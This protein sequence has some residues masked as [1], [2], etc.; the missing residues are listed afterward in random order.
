MLPLQVFDAD[1]QILLLHFD[2]VDVVPEDEFV[3]ALDGLFDGD[4]VFF[5]PETIYNTFLNFLVHYSIL[6]FL[7]QLA[8]SF[9]LV[10]Y[11]VS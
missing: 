4:I 6:Q 9:V 10:L 7:P 8:G 2:L 1:F 5:L 3:P 11:L